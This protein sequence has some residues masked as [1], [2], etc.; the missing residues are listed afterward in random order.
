MSSRTLSALE[1]DPIRAINGKFANIRTQ[2]QNAT[3]NGQMLKAVTNSPTIELKFIGDVNINN[4]M[5]IDDF[6][7]RVSNAIMQTLVCEVSKW[8]G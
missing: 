4:D 8:G 6:N 7:R 1:G 5:D 3:V 2:S